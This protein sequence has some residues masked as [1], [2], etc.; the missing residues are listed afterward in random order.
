MSDEVIG[1]IN[2]MTSTQKPIRRRLSSSRSSSSSSSSN[3][4]SN[5]S[6]SSIT[7]S[8]TSSSN[9]HNTG[10]RPLDENTDPLQ[11]SSRHTNADPQPG[12]SRD[13]NA[14]PQPRTS[15]D[16]FSP[17]SILTPIC[18]D[19]P[20]VRPR[21][22]VCKY[23]ISPLHSEESDVD[24]SDDDPSYIQEKNHH[25][26][27]LS[28]AAGNSID[29]YVPTKPRK[30]KADPNKWMQNT[31]KIKRNLGQSYVAVHSKKLVLARNI[32]SPCGRNRRLK[33]SDRIDNS[34]RV[35]IFNAFWALGDRQLQRM[36]ILSNS[37][38]ITPKY[39]YTNAQNPRNPHFILL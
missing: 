29:D 32:K 10:R 12:T 8:S 20:L 35:Q 28:P 7:S 21:T 14:D 37:T 31:Q 1:N 30:R 11:D 2:V 22:A 3:S 4:R 39:K 26:R 24:L 16:N 9:A 17:P 18:N 13:E 6:N 25:Q 23:I 5:S 19:L 36:Y 34:K 15:R 27:S 33:C 38:K